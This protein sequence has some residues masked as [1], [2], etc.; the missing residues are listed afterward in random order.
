MKDKSKQRLFEIMSRLDHNFNINENNIEDAN[1]DVQMVDKLKTPA[2]KN[3]YG[4]INFRDELKDAFDMWF[5]NLG[6][7][8][9]HKDRINITTTLEDIRDVLVKYGIKT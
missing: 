2:Q 1:T 9:E 4:R 8:N 7:A 3:A 5:S 6:V